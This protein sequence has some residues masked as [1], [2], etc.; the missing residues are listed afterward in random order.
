MHATALFIGARVRRAP[1]EV[2]GRGLH[3][4]PTLHQPFSTLSISGAQDLIPIKLIWDYIK[5]NTVESSEAE[6]KVRSQ[7]AP[8]L[9]KAS[10]SVGRWRVANSAMEAVPRGAEISGRSS[11]AACDAINHTQIVAPA[12]TRCLPTSAG[13]D[14]VPRRGTAFFAGIRRRNVAEAEQ[15]FKNDRA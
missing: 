1:R 4:G 3:A 5:I 11:R 13:K 7:P 14:R 6:H 10:L 2:P 9:K 15:A 8:L 12:G